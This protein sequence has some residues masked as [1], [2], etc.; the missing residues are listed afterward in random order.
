MLS[1][2][3]C[4]TAGFTAGRGERASQAAGAPAP[5]WGGTDPPSR[6]LRGRGTCLCQPQT[7]WSRCDTETQRG[8]DTRG[9]GTRTQ[10]QLQGARV[11]SAGTAQGCALGPR[12]QAGGHA[13]RQGTT[14]PGGGPRAQAGDHAPRQGTTRPGGGPR[15]QAGVHRS[16]WGS[17]VR[18]HLQ[19]TAS[20][21]PAMASSST[22]VASSSVTTRSC[23]SPDVHTQRKGPNPWEKMSLQGQKARQLGAS[24]AGCTPW[25]RSPWSTVGEAADAPD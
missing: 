20:P 5:W 11:P 4:S 19:P 16:L 24:Q 1:T 15:A 3:C 21:P 6:R 12:A 7:A 14:G 8:L 22:D 23:G 9:R 13:P 18:Q 25:L 2:Y 17:P 10:G